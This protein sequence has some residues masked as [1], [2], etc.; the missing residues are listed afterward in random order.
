MGLLHVSC[1]EHCLNT[2][3]VDHCEIC[4][5]RFA[6]VAQATGIR[7]FF[8]WALH[9]GSLWRALGVLICFAV[10]TPLT[11][12]TC[13]YCIQ[14]TSKQAL[15]G[16]IM[17]FVSVVTL[18]GLFLT[19]Y[20]CSFFY[21]VR[22]H[23]CDIALW[24]AQNSKRKTWVWRSAVPNYGQSRTPDGQQASSRKIVDVGAASFTET[25]RAM[26]LIV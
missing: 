20:L 16:R 15:E 25:E 12:L 24:Q 21:I 13:F 26:Q 9:A 7:Q 2:Q 17:V 8:C 4:H 11:V 19:A 1:L 6:T 18:S 3:N 22:L 14:I 23:Y 5:H 10:M